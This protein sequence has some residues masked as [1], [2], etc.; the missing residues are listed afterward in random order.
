MLQDT[1]STHWIILVVSYIAFL[2]ILAGWV[3][4]HLSEAVQSLTRASNGLISH[5][6]V[7]NAIEIGVVIGVVILWL[8][9]LTAKD[10]GLKWHQLLRGVTVGLALW[11]LV[12][13][14]Q[15]LIG[16]AK[17]GRVA[18]D[19]VWAE[20][21]VGPML[22]LLIG[23]L[24]GTSLCEE[25]IFRG[26][27]LPQLWLTLRSRMPNSPKLTV[28][29]AVLASQALFAFM[30]LP[31]QIAR[32]SEAGDLPFIVLAMLFNGVFYAIIYLRTGNLFIAMVI[33]AFGNVPTPVPMAFVNSP[34][35]LLVLTL[36]LLLVWPTLKRW[37]KLGGNSQG[38]G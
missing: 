6:L 29:L 10:I 22:G 4:L 26:F 1:K 25:A 35:L 21:G 28:S 31:W 33:H 9:K 16:L 3:F 19:P 5:L 14:I 12:Q 20:E 32:G 15:L 7:L 36:L 30:H 37:L 13:I 8:G 11:V 17:T 23:H 18:L 34:S 24:L 27:F 38:M 2:A